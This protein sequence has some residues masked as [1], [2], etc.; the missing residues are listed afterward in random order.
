[1]LINTLKKLERLPLPNEARDQ[2][3]QCGRALTLPLLVRQLNRCHAGLLPPLV[4]F[5][6]PGAPRS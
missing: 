6:L 3:P 5:D 2:E 1:M 4:P